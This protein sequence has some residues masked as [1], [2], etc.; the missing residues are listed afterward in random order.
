M[1]ELNDVLAAMERAAADANALVDS[2]HERRPCPT[3]QQPI[4]SPCV[5]VRYLAMPPWM[6]RETKHPHESRWS[7]D[8]AKR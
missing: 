5:N 3:C 6:W 8:V 4:G 1:T 2:C 7:P